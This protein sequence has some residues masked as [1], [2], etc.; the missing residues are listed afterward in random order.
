MIQH[1]TKPFRYFFKLEAASGLVLL[2]AA[3]LALIISNGDYSENYFTILEKYLT[4]GTENFGLKLSVL[5]WIND[6]FMDGGLTIALEADGF[7]YNMV[8]IVVGTL[9]E[10]GMGRRASED[11]R[12]ILEAAD[13]SHAGP[14]AP[15]AGLCLE[16]VEYDVPHER[17]LQDGQS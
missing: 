10:V 4:L 1:I 15:A 2:F 11:V 13:R 8:R 7:L 12:R 3:I 16:H 17:S 9:V 14:T 6:V 5:H